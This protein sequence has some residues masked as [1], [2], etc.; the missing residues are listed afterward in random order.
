MKK[1]KTTNIKLSACMIVKNEEAMLERCLNS[2]KHLVDEIIIVDTGSTDRTVK[3]AQSFNTRIFHHPWED[4]FSRHRNQSISYATGDW[5]L[6]I[7]ADE[8]LDATAITK[9]KLK[10]T[11][12]KKSKNENALFIPVLEKNIAGEVTNTIKRVRF[13]R[14][15]ADFIYRGTVHNTPEYKGGAGEL[16][17]NLFHYGY[18]LPEEKM[19]ERYKRT[20]YLLHRRVEQNT[21]DYHAYFYLSQLCMQMNEEDKGIEYAKRCLDLLKTVQE[22]D[23][24]IHFYY[25]IYH[26]LSITLI[27]KEDYD[28]ALEIV[29]EGLEKL[30]DETDLLYD[31]ACTG[32]FLN[33]HNIVIEGG[34]AFIRSVDQQKNRSSAKDSVS[35]KIIQ[36][37]NTCLVSTTTSDA[38]SALEFWL[39]SAYIALKRFDDYEKL[40]NRC[41]EAF[42][43]NTELHE[44]LLS[45]LERADRWDLLEKVIYALSN[46]QNTYSEEFETAMLEYKIFLERKKDAFQ[47][48]EA[49]ITKFLDL[50]KDYETMNLAT[51]VIIAEYMLKVNNGKSF[52]Q[53]TAVI[54]NN[55]LEHELDNVKNT[56]K[57]ALAYN[58]VAQQQESTIKGN[59]TA[60]ACLNIAWILSD[61]Q[62]Y[63]DSIKNLKKGGIF[64][65]GNIAISENITIKEPVNEPV[66]DSNTH[67]LKIHIDNIK[68]PV[69]SESDSPACFHTS[70]GDFNIT[71]KVS[72][73]N[74]VFLQGIIGEDRKAIGVGSPLRMQLLLIED[75]SQTKIL[76][77]AADI[78]GFGSEMVEI[79]RNT[80]SQWG[81]SSE[82]II[83]NASHT[84]YGPGTLSHT[85]RT[86][87]PYFKEYATEIAGIVGNSLSML[88]DNLEESHI[89]SG[90]TDVSIGVNVHGIPGKNEKIEFQ[91]YKT[92]I[93]DQHTPFLLL[94]LKKSNKKIIMVNHGC[95]PTGLGMENNISADFPGYFREE[96]LKTGKVDHVMYLQGA[97]GDIKE[98]STLNGK[99]VLSS[100]S[101]DAQKNG[102]IMAQCIETALDNALLK[103]LTESSIFCTSQ[104]MY[105]RLK[106]VPDINRINQ[107]KNDLLS[108]PVIREWAARLSATYPLGDF[109]NALALDVLVSSIGNNSTFICFPAGSVAELGISLK[110]ITSYPENTFVLGYTNGMLCYLLDDKSIDRGGYESEISPYYYMIPYLLA[111]GTD[112]EIILNVKE[113][114]SKINT[115]I[116]EG[117]YHKKSQSLEKI[118]AQNNDNEQNVFSST[119]INDVFLK[120]I[121]PDQWHLKTGMNICIISDFNIA[122]GLTGLMRGINKYSEHKARCIIWHDDHFSYDKDIILDECGNDYDEAIEI[123]KN[124]DFYHFGRYIF[125]FPGIKFDNFVTPRNCLV[126]YYGSVLRENGKKCN[127]WHKKTGIAALTANDFTITS[128]LDKSFYH[129]HHYYF[130]KYGDMDEKDIPCAEY[131]EGIVKIVAGSGGSPLKGYDFLQTT[132]KKLQK[133]GLPVD[134]EIIKGVSNNECLHRKQKCHITFTSLHGGWGLSGVESMF[135]GHPVMCCLD[136]FVLSLYPDAP[137]IVVDRESLEAQIIDLVEN[138]DK[139]VKTGMESRKFALKYFRIKNIIKSCL[140]TYDLIMNHEKYQQGNTKASKIY[141]F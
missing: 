130:S 19:Q 113:C 124:A 99:Q 7:D 14:N 86:M 60:L 5:I 78:F 112:A 8:E 37:N 31:L 89:Y 121:P 21:D 92:G 59:I 134:V 123:V 107:L 27:D 136:P 77:V 119:Q 133:K 66:K 48:L 100:T 70:F 55:Y 93:Y 115:L 28:T 83:L 137:S 11:L 45:A 117:S 108:A 116:E 23:A 79:I 91:P 51:L 53:I 74:P 128:L 95:Q 67:S 140:Y 3:I 10:E 39:M 4:D 81:I 56:K 110:N 88:H 102:R 30:P 43:K 69:V 1:K 20:S 97:S 75:E 68:R 82:R 52:L 105:L 76:F 32:Y 25:S 49:V 127:A 132:V 63:L 73:E 85:F 26:I 2:I 36:V 135:L 38:V 41:Q 122:G 13:F 139:L 44:P 58:M 120:Q 109:P 90:N 29:Q 46:R 65:P 125:D 50:T 34:E 54:L 111:Q 141:T 6:V 47:S 126:A 96:L 33:H 22:K 9:N 24:D 138:R 87:G 118:K 129:V 71:P 35:E 17:L 62:C 16:D 84:H 15:N 18:A 94:E 104:T 80:A 114:Y 12:K 101:Q 64:Q 42:L 61:D 40:W 57:L 131:P 72:D 103:P 106:K 98:A